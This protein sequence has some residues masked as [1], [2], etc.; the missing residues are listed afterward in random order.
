[1][2][3]SRPQLRVPPGA[4]DTHI[5]IYES[6]F[7]VVPGGIAPREEA[8]VSA[9]RNVMARLG[10]ERVILVQPSAYGFDNSCL[11]EA[12][13]SLGDVARG[14]ATVGPDTTDDELQRLTDAGVRGAR[15][16]MLPGGS[17]RW[18]WLETVAS[19][20]QEFGWHI[21]MQCDGRLLPDHAAVLKR[22]SGTL[23]IDHV[24]KFLEP[25]TTEHPGFRVILDLLAGG[26]CWVK[27]AAPYETSKM[28]PPLYSD[29]GALAKALVRAAP[30]R[31]VWASNW[32]HTSV[33]TN[34]PDD[35][36]LLD[37]LQ[38]WAPDPAVQRK[39][40]RENP[41]A[42]YGFERVTQSRR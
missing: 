26:R 3:E 8:P 27:L 24:G 20:V 25:V 17:T 33:R 34:P 28:G 35:A 9:Y 19:R 42:L 2:S 29:T 31:L 23:V 40:L 14:V 16:F 4:C 12:L 5:H 11:L 22:L 30:D 6:R 7:P 13:R 32:P 18:E 38:D 15:F 36:M 37:I 21:Q 39:I 1:M 41:A 10:L